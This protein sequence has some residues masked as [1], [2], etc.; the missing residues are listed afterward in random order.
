MRNFSVPLPTLAVALFLLV[1]FTALCDA[2]EPSDN[3]DKF[4]YKVIASYPHDPDAYTQ[5]LVID[6]GNLFEG[7]GINGK[8]SLR[9]VQLETGEVLQLY[10]IPTQFFSEGITVFE[11]R[12]IQL[13]WKSKFGFVFDKSSFEL[14]QVFTYPY[15]GWGLTDD[16]SQLISSDGTATIRFL[17]PLNFEEERK[18]EVM[19]K[20]G[21]VINL[22]ELEYVNGM[23]YAN[24]WRT[25]RIA[26]IDPKDG[27]VTGWID[28][29]GLLGK[30]GDGRPVDVLNGIAY[31]S[32]KDSLYV[33]G[34]LWPRLFEIQPVL[35][36]KK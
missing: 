1:I 27:R 17:D 22:N 7:T 32:D 23:I 11:N 24:V 35:L 20:N 12:I 13:N 28:L 2:T 33:T 36:Q 29:T 8:S 3:V 16:G 15:E 14:L 26:I 6:E 10:K 30:E 25:D 31:D 21:P 19:D 4:T 34:K 18:I 5:G 9:R